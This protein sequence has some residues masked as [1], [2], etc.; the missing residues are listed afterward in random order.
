MLRISKWLPPKLLLRE[1][2]HAKSWGNVRVP[3]MNREWS[4]YTSE[5]S[6]GR[7]RVGTNESMRCNQNVLQWS[8]LGRVYGT[9]AVISPSSLSGKEM[10]FQKAWRASERGVY[11]HRARRLL[12][13]SSHWKVGRNQWLERDRFWRC[14]HLSLQSIIQERHRWQNRSSISALFLHPL[15]RFLDTII[16]FGTE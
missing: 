1:P 12:V 5:I 8:L 7:E 13:C 15:I 14:S 10:S 3:K 2:I 6:S 16:W 4:V 9:N 11:L